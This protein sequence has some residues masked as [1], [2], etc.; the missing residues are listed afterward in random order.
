MMPHLHS[1]EWGV[2][3]ILFTVAGRDVPSYSVFMLLAV[4]VGLL[5]F[6]R[7]AARQREQSEGTVYVL[8]GA[9]FGGVLGAK[10]PVALVYGREIIARFPDLTLLLTGRSIVGGLI[11][12][13]IGVFL[14]KR[15]LKMTARR[16]NLFVPGI[17][18]GVA[19]GRVGCFLRGC[20][21]GTPTAR[22]WGVDFGD[23]IMRHPTQLYEAL[24]MAALLPLALWAVRRVSRPPGAVFKA[25]MAIYFLQRFLVEFVREQDVFWLGLTF[26]QW[27]AAA[28]VLF[29]GVDV[30]RLLREE[31]RVRT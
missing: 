3:P 31:R 23:G 18:A 12:G 22:P 30:V 19:V 28:V 20:C 11:G 8:L 24:L 10:L 7:E 29:Y 6:W 9:L 17:V 4:G 21:Y 25:F 15:R 26:F 13:A 27:V 5:L 1:A 14:V 2:R 16:G